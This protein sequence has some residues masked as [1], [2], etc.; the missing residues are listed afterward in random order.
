MRRVRG[1]AACVSP[2]RR[3]RFGRAVPV[4]GLVGLIL[5][6]VAIVGS[7]PSASASQPS[8]V[9]QTQWQHVI[10]E[11]PA[12]TSGC[13]A[14][15]YPSLLWQSM[16]CT[17]APKVPFSPAHATAAHEAPLRVG[18]AADDVAEVTGKISSVTGSFDDVDPSITETGKFAN[19]GTTLAN[20]Y[21]LQ[22]NSNTFTD[23]TACTASPYKTNT[24]RGWE[25]FVYS[26]NPTT[27]TS[28]SRDSLFIQYWLIDYT[29]SSDGNCPLS[30]T[31]RSFTKKYCVSTSRAATFGSTITAADLA[32]T[33][34]TGSAAAGGDDTEVLVFGGHAVSVTALDSVLHLA[35][36]WKKAEF[37][38][39]GD[40]SGGTA[41]FGATT[42][43]EPELALTDTTG[44]T[45]PT[46]VANGGTTAE[47]NNLTLTATPAIG[48]RATPS[49]AF[50][51]TNKATTT[52]SCQTA[53]G[54][55][56]SKLA[57]T[58]EPGTIAVG[59]SFTVGVSIETSSGAVETA[60]TTTVS[61]AIS[62]GRTTA[63]LTCTGSTNDR[64]NA[65]SGVATF[66]CE[67]TVADTGYT[68]KASATGLASVTTSA[69]N[70]SS[71]STPTPTISHFTPTSG[72]TAGGTSV[73]ITGTTLAKV[74]SVTLGTTAGTVVSATS[75]SVTATSPTHAAGTVT[76]KVTTSTG[77]TTTASTDYTYV[78]PAPTPPTS[79]GQGYHEVASD[80][81]M[82][83]FGDAVFH[84]SMGG[85]PLNE[86][87]VAMATDSATGGYW[88]VASD[89]GIF[90]FTAPFYGSMGAKP[91]DKPIV[92]MA[93]MPT[94][95][96]YWE[97]ASDGG[98]FSFGNAVFHGSMGGKPL[99]EP[100]VAIATDPAASG[101]WEVASDGGIFSFTAP[102]YGSMGG[103]PLNKP[104]VG[105]ATDPATGGYWE[106]ASDGG[107]FSFT[108]PF[109]GSMGG[110]PLNEPIVGIAAT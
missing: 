90:S 18:N 39:F 6:A 7:S 82:F 5:G 78:T 99:N 23:T 50:V 64:K 46:C 89:G 91:L 69:F 17:V 86:P 16:K 29:A 53:A 71:S 9:T 57:I 85:K 25:Q 72:T 44:T 74:T 12:P 76:I 73:V 40:G 105:M 98:I 77:A 43:L 75:D 45:A 100:I 106:V 37:N 8:G 81:G 54:S 1:E 83:T 68:I 92:G 3:F 62:A 87:I 24:Y 2:S 48:S 33:Q 102:F 36:G 59:Q 67:I 13:Y 26:S 107:I 51:E 4:A 95:G 34:L 58:D 20:T 52:A 55:A 103:K 56:G 104:I 21:S 65:T 88:E 109:Y 15:S 42:T 30:G 14:A 22:L 31:W 35:A 10:A 94:G 60:N 97:V 27:T 93:A 49:I 32:T 19:A 96:G 47:T 63:T 61:L 11:T 38:V 80:G 79:S 110:K 108:A 84:G 41:N 28:K 101:Y 66:D 70:I